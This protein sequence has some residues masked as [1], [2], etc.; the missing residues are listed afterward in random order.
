MREKIIAL[1]Q[2]KIEVTKPERLAEEITDGLIEEGWLELSEI[3]L[4]ERIRELQG[5]LD[6]AECEVAVWNSRA[7]RVN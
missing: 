7:N 2:K 5:K 3:A 6:S 4:V 1:I